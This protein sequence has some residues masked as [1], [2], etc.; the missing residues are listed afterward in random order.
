MG[1]P[2]LPPGTPTGWARSEVTIVCRN[3]DCEEFESPREVTEVYERDTGAAWIEPED[4]MSC[5]ACDSEM[6]Y[7]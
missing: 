3:E 1:S 6:V 2:Y 4:A 5:E 7:A